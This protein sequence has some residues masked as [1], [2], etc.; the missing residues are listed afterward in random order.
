MVAGADV[1][2]FIVVVIGKSGSS[3]E[4]A[5]ARAARARSWV[6]AV[7]RFTGQVDA[8]VPRRDAW[9]GLR[10]GTDVEPAPADPRRRPAA[11]VPDG[12]GGL[13]VRGAEDV[14]RLDVVGPEAAVEPDEPLDGL[15]GEHAVGPRV[16]LGVRPRS[17][18]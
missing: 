10:S 11:E 15:A 16:G 2:V 12:P 17:S 7:D 5:R 1:A 8:R 3:H 14:R 13:D 9:I 6:S 18:S 4:V